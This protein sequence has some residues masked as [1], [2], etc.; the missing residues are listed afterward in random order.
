MTNPF[1]P[2]VGVTGFAPTVIIAPAEPKPDENVVVTPS[3]K[4]WRLEGFAP[5]VIVAP[6][7][8]EP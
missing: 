2:N 6:A 1:V 5:E 8:P 4:E 3:P 7:K